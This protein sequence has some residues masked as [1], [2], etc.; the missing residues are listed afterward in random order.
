MR[1]FGCGPRASTTCA[2]RTSCFFANNPIHPRSVWVQPVL[3]RA[4][5]LSA[6]DTKKSRNTVTLIRCGSSRIFRD[7][8]LDVSPLA[9]VSASAGSFAGVLS[10]SSLLELSASAAAASLGASSSYMERIRYT[11][12][13]GKLE[14]YH[15]LVHGILNFRSGSLGAL[16]IGDGIL[17]KHVRN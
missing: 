12:L 16:V 4:L 10:E 5:V 14:T 13:R 1:A 6:K 2:R 8:Y 15:C 17:E 3:Q 9:S 7:N 11:I